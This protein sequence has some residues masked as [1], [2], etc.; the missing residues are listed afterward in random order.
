MIPED[1]DKMG[2]LGIHTV[3]NHD[4][5]MEKVKERVADSCVLGLIKEFL[6]QGVI[7]E[8]V[9]WQPP[10]SSPQG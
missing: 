6:K 10:K 1:K 3:I 2:P 9:R 7:E 5:L 4:I 8:G